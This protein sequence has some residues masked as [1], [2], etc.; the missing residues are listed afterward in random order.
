MVNNFKSEYDVIRANAVT[1]V[2]SYIASLA[3][4]DRRKVNL[5]SIIS[6][7]ITLLKDPNPQ[8]RSKAAEALALLHDV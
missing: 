4:N 3:M 6:A 2:G 1:F 8:V 7:S 5:D